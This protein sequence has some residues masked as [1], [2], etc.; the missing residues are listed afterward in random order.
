MQ[1][2][3]NRNVRA[4][5]VLPMGVGRSVAFRSHIKGTELPPANILTPL[6][7][8][9]RYNFAA[10]SVLY[11]GTLQ[12]TLRPIVEIVQKTTNLGNLSPF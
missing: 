8:Q 3:P 1:L 10:G 5:Q 4:T 9:L 12:Q 7:R 11:N 6:E 2:R